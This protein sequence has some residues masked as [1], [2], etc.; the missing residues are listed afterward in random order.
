MADDTVE[1]YLRKTINKIRMDTPW[2]SAGVTEDSVIADDCDLHDFCD[3][4][5]VIE[6]SMDIEDKY[7]FDVAD[8]AL[9][10]IRT[11]KELVSFVEQKLASAKQPT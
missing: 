11:Y 8:D 10:D 1:L 9:D 2:A 3:S 5:D 6:I 4:L 7:D